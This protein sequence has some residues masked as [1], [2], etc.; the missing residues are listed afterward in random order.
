MHGF[1]GGCSRMY[2]VAASV[3]TSDPTNH[4]VA[5]KRSSKARVKL[6]A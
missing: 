6:A 2:D 3:T 5:G 4:T 1:D